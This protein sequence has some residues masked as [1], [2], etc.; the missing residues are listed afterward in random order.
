MIINIAQRDTIDQKTT[1]LDVYHYS[2]ISKDKKK[3]YFMMLFLAADPDSYCV[4]KKSFF[5]NKRLMAYDK[6]ENINGLISD[7]WDKRAS[8]NKVYIVERI[9]SSEFKIIEVNIYY[10][11]NSNGVIVKQL[12]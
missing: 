7:K 3:Q 12:K 4:V 11:F 1:Q 8:Y 2:Y 6:L 9:D 10:P 5:D